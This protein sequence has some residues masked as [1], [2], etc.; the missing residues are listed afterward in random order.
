[1]ALEKFSVSPYSYCLTPH[2]L[3]DRITAAHP[4]H[5]HSRHNR[6]GLVDPP[7]CTPFC[8]QHLSR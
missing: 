2:E 3:A 8:N 6:F 4:R 7:H 5:N 1:M